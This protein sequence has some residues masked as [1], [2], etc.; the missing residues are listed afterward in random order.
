MALV[1][2][3]DSIIDINKLLRLKI[4]LKVLISLLD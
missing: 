2:I 3:R 1:L 4:Y